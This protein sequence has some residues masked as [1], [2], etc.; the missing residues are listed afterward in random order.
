M[1]WFWI[2]RF[3]EFESGRRAAAEKAVT[4]AEEQLD[5]Y[6]PGFPV[7][8][9]SLIIE[10]FAQTGGLLV[11][12]CRQFE[13]RTVLAKVGRAQFFREV[14]PGD[15]MRFEVAIQD[16][17]DDGAIVHGTARVGDQLVADVEIVFAH[18]DDR[19]EGVDL[20]FPADFLTILRLLG[21]YDVGRTADGKPLVI[22]AR[23]LAAE[24]AAN[25]E[26]PSSEP[27]AAR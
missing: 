17:R 3:V 19:F 18:L 16:L 25:R 23:L 4:L 15:V 21:V 7:M 11:G 14:R 9:A 27:D 13:Q 24:A 5:D 12:E 1:R 10:G 6:V 2:D 8:P 20:F 22:P 26:G